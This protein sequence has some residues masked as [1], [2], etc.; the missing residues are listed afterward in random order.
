VLIAPAIV[1]LSIGPDENK[2]IRYGIAAAALVIVIAAVA[3]SKSRDLAIGGDD[4][5]EGATPLDAS[6]PDSGA[7]DRD[8]TVVVEEVEVVEV[9][10]VEDARPPQR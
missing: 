3:V 7:V 10:E 9:V 4:D 6:A 2:A 8:G 1:T 5:G